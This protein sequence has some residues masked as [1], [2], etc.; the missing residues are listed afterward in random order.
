MKSLSILISR[1][2]NSRLIGWLALH[3]L[4]LFLRLCS[5]PSFGPYFFVS[6]IWQPPY[7]CVLGRATLTP[8][9]SGAIHFL[10]CMRQS[11][12]YSPERAPTS[13]LCRSMCWGGFKGDSEKCLELE[14][15]WRPAEP[16]TCMI[17]W[18]VKRGSWC[19]L[20][21]SWQRVTG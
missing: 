6:S 2:L 8:C 11:L 4:V 1:V 20:E 7:V 14:S 13:L 3:R 12:G 18:G 19:N 9:L 10:S 21:L 15:D 17:L 16:P 5:V